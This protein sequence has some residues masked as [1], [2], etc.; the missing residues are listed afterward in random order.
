M[1]ATFAWLTAALEKPTEASA[2]QLA[3]NA[4]RSQ[5]EP[6]RDQAAEIDPSTRRRFGVL[7]R[8]V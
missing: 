4:I 2:E 7:P 1:R 3:L 6:L 8:Q 5:L